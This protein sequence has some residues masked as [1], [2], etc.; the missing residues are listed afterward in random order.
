M[1]KVFK[2]LFSS[3]GVAR[4]TLRVRPVKKLKPVDNHRLRADVETYFL[5]GNC[6]N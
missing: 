1:E 4:V 2:L 3:D 5:A 6:F